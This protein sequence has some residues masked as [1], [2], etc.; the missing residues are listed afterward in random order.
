MILQF[1]LTKIQFQV[2][3]SYLVSPHHPHKRIVILYT[4]RTRYSRISKI[5]LYFYSHIEYFCK[6]H[7]I[8]SQ[9][10]FENFIKVDRGSR[11]CVYIGAPCFHLKMRVSSLSL[12][13]YFPYL[14]RRVSTRIRVARACR[15]LA[16]RT[17]ARV[18]FRQNRK[19]GRG[20]RG[21][22]LHTLSLPLTL[23]PTLPPWRCTR[24]SRR[25]NAG[26][27][28]NWIMHALFR[29]EREGQR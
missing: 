25:V 19:R 22:P 11:G 15:P 13:F 3:M 6:S 18:R 17:R 29:R 27:A 2:V 26:F 10:S 14:L 12:S 20:R 7:L 1:F 4:F 9:E 23:S 21:P 24:C 16:R 8:H 28:A 5:T